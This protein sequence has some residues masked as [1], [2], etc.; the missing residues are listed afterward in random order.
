[1]KKNQV[2]F[3]V[4]ALVLVMSFGYFYR[5]MLQIKS[6]STLHQNS[7]VSVFQSI[8]TKPPTS[9]QSAIISGTTALD[10]LKQTAKIETKGEGVNTYVVTINGRTAS[11]T[12]K[13][14]WAFYVNSKLASVGAGSYK[15]MPNDKIVWKIEKFQ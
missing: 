9:E 1:M 11:N 5:Q 2:I 10:L 3:F 7:L 6:S 13:E 14:Y 12:D 8:E 4:A 15:L